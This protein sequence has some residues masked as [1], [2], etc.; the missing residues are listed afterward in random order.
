MRFLPKFMVPVA[1]AALAA[2]T[3][4]AQ[5]STFVESDA[6][7]G[8]ANPG[9]ATQVTYTIPANW[10]FIVVG[11]LPVVASVASNPASMAAAVDIAGAFTGNGQIYVGQWT[12]LST[13]SGIQTS[14]A[15]QAISPLN[16]LNG[17]ASV[18]VRLRCSVG[19]MTG[20]CIFITRMTPSGDPL[21]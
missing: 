11:V 20:S 5:A 15:Y 17:A 9:T 16:L 6:V 3:L 14:P 13:A 7:T 18:Q 8:S 1:A 21:F 10:S 4:S 12:I 2:T 19:N